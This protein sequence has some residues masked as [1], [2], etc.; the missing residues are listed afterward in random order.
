MTV[1]LHP[2]DLG[3]IFG[4]FVI[5]LLIGFHFTHKRADA[6]DYFLAGRRLG[7][8]VIGF[9]LF[10]SNISSTTLIGLSGAAY[11]TGISI[12]NYEWMAA[13]ILV[14][15]AVFFVPYYISSRVYTLPEFLE[16]RFQ[17]ACRYYFSIVTLIGNV[18]IDTAATLFAGALV[19]QFF[20]PAIGM[21]EA[22][23]GLALVAGVYTAAG[24]LAAV[25]YTD[26][27]QAIII[28]VGASALTLLAYHAIGSW[29][30]VQV[31]TPP[32]MLSMIRPLDDPTMPWLGLIIGVPI[33]GFYFWCTNQFI[34]QRVLG[35]RDI[36]QARW[37]VLFAGLLKLP[38]LFI[39][40]FPGIMARLLYPDLERADLV[41]P[42]LV[43][44]LL[45]IGVK[46]LVLA[47]FIAAI[48]SSI[49]STLNSA[50]TLI[51]M[52]FVKKLRPRASSRQL[53][54]VGRVATLVFMVVSVLWIQVVA[55][56]STLF[57]YLQSA[58]AYL[59]PP[60]AAIFIL[61]LFWKRASGAGALSGFIV[62]HAVSLATLLSQQ[63]ND[64]PEVH[65]LI[66]A[67][68]FFGVAAVTVIIVSL[69]TA[70]P[71]PEQVRRYVWS[72][73]SVREV[74]QGLPPVSW[75]KDYR[76]QSVALLLLTACLVWVYR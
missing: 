70:P 68:V 56:F 52:D 4:Y 42:T 17:P 41:F 30:V 38:V 25:V 46:G 62:G 9:S 7:W 33:L 67:G 40:V 11:L 60:V 59:V 20:F 1:D 50:S 71:S 76:C 28:L 15:F 58:L 22:A 18:F 48:M 61:G 37:G 57:G 55:E 66:L 3:L 75:Y 34:V 8:V 69:M 10:A 19:I 23:L 63:F 12:S 36:Q 53:A 6:E 5:V 73:A 43:S 39:M 65:F 54:I 32:E 21:W 44:D 64:F 47:A 27:I 51:T 26:V 49:D 14:F 16:R 2:F 31:A 29:E 35:A 74:T 72:K 24:G 45:P 13:V